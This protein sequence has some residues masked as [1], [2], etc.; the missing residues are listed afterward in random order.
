ME[1]IQLQW[2]RIQNK[3]L[4]F[5]MLIP[6]ICMGWM[7]HSFGKC[8]VAYHWR[9]WK[10]CIISL[11]I[12]G[13]CSFEI[14]GV[15]VGDNEL[16]LLNVHESPKIKHLSFSDKRNQTQPINPLKAKVFNWTLEE[17][18]KLLIARCEYEKM[19]RANESEEFI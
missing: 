13:G 19:R 16:V 14:N 8:T 18:E 5:L 12:N 17:K 15:F 9:N 7:P 2:L 6:V 1:L 11:L 4:T 3:A 10:P